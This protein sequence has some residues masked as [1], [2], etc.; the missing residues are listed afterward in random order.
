MMHRHSCVKVCLETVKVQVL[1]SVC[2]LGQDISL[3]CHLNST[4]QR[5]VGSACS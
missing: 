1:G 5:A 4:S 3:C 2:V